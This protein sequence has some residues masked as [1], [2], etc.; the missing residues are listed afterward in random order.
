MFVCVCFTSLQQRGH[1]ETA[2]PF[3]VPCE[4]RLTSVY[5]EG[6]LL[7]RVLAIEYG[8]VLSCVSIILQ[9]LVLLLWILLFVLDLRLF[10]RLMSYRDG[11]CF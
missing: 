10:Q 7:L 3:I 9:H 5:C 1:L 2:P 8:V 4:G 11:A 6:I